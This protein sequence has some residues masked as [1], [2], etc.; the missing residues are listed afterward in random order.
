MISRKLIVE[1]T[2]M[3]GAGNDFI[4]IDNRFFF[5]DEEELSRLAKTLCPRR[6]GIG[7][8]GLLAFNEP[9]DPSHHYRM[10]Y[11][12]A[13][14]SLGTMCGN[15]ARCLARFA[16]LVGMPAGELVFESD[17]GIYK[18]LINENEDEP[19]RLYVQPPAL[20]VE[21][22]QVIAPEANGHQVAGIW[23]GTEHVVL[24][25]DD[26]ER[27]P[28]D[29]VGPAIRGDAALA[30]TGANVNFVQVMD[31]G[32]TGEA[33]L[34]VRT[35]E[36]GV[37]AETLACGTGAMASVVIAFKKGLIQ[38]PKGAVFMPGGQLE[39]GF[40]VSGEGLIENLY[41]EGP[42]QTIYRGTFEWE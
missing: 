6:T 9:D 16:V 41:L 21:E 42:A 34:R 12:N 35:Y 20:Y 27:A 32:H 36:K 28:V 25:V 19:V 7:A 5:F 17:A 10:K 38:K 2:K 1:F 24:F 13:D 29:T 3:S 39:V 30:P 33:R 22:V 4:V 31:D 15:G 37:E 18:A 23:T 14:G 26:V 40:D 8:D 11:M